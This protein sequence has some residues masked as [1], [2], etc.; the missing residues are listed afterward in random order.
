M[1]TYRQKYTYEELTQLT[2]VS[3]LQQNT[4]RYYCLHIYKGTP[5]CH[6]LKLIATVILITHT[7]REQVYP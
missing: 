2:S 1:V 4:G 5:R 6:A 3:Q 7:L